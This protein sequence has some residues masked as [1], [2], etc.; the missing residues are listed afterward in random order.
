MNIADIARLIACMFVPGG[1]VLA[2]L[3]HAPRPVPARIRLSR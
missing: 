2:P 3:L 1:I